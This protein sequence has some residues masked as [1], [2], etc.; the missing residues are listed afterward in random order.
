MNA[1]R[2]EAAF[3]SAFLRNRNV[4]AG[5]AG[6]G[7]LPVAGGFALCIAGTFYERGIGIGTTRP[8]RADDLVVL[9]EFYGRRGL[10]AR[11]ELDEA[12]LA[13]DRGLLEA[14]GYAEEGRANGMDGAQ[15]V[16]ESPTAGIGPVEGIGVRTVT[17][18]RA[19]TELLVR[20]IADTV[21]EADR[22]RL[23]RSVQVGAL[24]AHGL[25]VASLDGADA[26]AGALGISGDVAYF[27]GAGVLPAFRRRGVHR[28]LVAARTAFAHERGA[29]QAAFKTSPGSFAERSALSLGFAVTGRLRCLRRP[30]AG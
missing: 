9:S 26:G 22:E 19:W 17:D 2:A 8:L 23:R 24:A 30:A 18:R 16:L 27:F 6:D 28:A 1:A 20:A 3:W 15:A 29:S 7:A 21:A 14:G 11:L 5:T 4:D 12:V 25:F 13:R 10:P